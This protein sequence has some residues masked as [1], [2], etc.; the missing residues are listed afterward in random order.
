MN[1]RNTIDTSP[2][3]GTY[4]RRNFNQP[5]DDGGTFGKRTN[6]FNCKSKTKTKMWKRV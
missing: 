4:Y 2:S 3:S 6:R 5:G 1:Q